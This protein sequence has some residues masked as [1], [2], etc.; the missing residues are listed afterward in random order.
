MNPEPEEWVMLSPISRQVEEHIAYQEVEARVEEAIQ[1][2]PPA[3]KTIFVMS[4]YE[5]MS[6]QEIANEL[7]LSV[8]TVENQM[9]K[10]L[11]TMRSYLK[12]YI[13]HLFQ[14]VL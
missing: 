11:K 6:Y 14:W 13:R 1:S 12:A 4:R 2:L 8:K 5:G 3:C 10:A 9:G 7:D